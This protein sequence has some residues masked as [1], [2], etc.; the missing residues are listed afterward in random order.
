MLD[1]STTVG[2]VVGFSVFNF[3]LGYVLGHFG[4]SQIKNDIE[5]IKGLIYGQAKVTVTP[6][7]VTSVTAPT[8]TVFPAHS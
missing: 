1:A 7:S 4:I 2:L 5:V 3:I 6:S 8:P